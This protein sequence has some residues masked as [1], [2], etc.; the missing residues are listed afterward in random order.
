MVWAFLKGLTIRYDDST[1]KSSFSLERKRRMQENWRS[2]RVFIFSNLVEENEGKFALK[3][4]TTLRVNVDSLGVPGPM[5]A[6][7]VGNRSC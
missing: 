7:Q 5:G 6:N 3:K 2:L 1:R 4:P